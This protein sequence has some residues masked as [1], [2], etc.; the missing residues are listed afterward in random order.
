MSGRPITDPVRFHDSPT[1]VT[2]DPDDRDADDLEWP[3]ETS[4]GPPNPPVTH[5]DPVTPVEPKKPQRLLTQV[6][7][8]DPT[9]DKPTQLLPE[10]LNRSSVV[11]G[12]YSTTST[13]YINLS[14][15]MGQLFSDTAGRI[16]P[17]DPIP[18][19]DNYTGPIWVTA[20][21]ASAA[22]TVSYWAVTK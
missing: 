13:D 3:T 10:D 19:F 9:W 11:I 18:L 16:Y 21:N 5:I 4:S 14:G 12:V 1:L 15:D 20:K 8:I 17:T 22:I 7:T 6:Q 2:G